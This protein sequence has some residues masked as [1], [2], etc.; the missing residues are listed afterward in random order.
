MKVT[1]AETAGLQNL[2]TEDIHR[3]G[4]RENFNVVDRV[5][6]AEA[7]ENYS[8]YTTY[9]TNVQLCVCHCVDAKTS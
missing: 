9:N 2:N 7:F 5:L 4:L 6:Q 1:D 8:K 3:V